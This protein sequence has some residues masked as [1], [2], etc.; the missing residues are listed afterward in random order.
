M[1]DHPLV[2]YELRQYI[3]KNQIEELLNTGLNLVMETL[4]SDPYST[5]A[6]TLIKVIYLYL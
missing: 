3:Q 4:P 1:T 5:M 2:S 6:A